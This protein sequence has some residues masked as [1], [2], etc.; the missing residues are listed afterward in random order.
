M[1]P[2]GKEEQVEQIPNEDTSLPPP[3]LSELEQMR[4]ELEAIKNPPRIR[5]TT[6][7]VNGSWEIEL[8]FGRQNDKTPEDVGSRLF[9]TWAE[10]NSINATVQAVL[11]N[12]V[13]KNVKGEAKVDGKG[14]AFIQIVEEQTKQ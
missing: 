10:W 8:A 9:F 6:A 5:V 13:K 11:E 12:G 14:R 4:Q 3:S 1:E 7:N 2:T